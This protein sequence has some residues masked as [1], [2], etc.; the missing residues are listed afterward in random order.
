[1]QRCSRK[2]ALTRRRE[3]YGLASLWAGIHGIVLVMEGNVKAGKTA[4]KVHRSVEPYRRERDVY[5][6]LSEAGVKQILG[7]RV[8][9]LIR[10]DDG[11][12]IVEMTVVTRPFVLDFAGAY[13]D[14]PPE[15]S[16][17]VWAEWQAAKREQFGARWTEVLA[18][19]GALEQLDIHMVDVSPT[20]IAF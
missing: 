10:S 16:E 15:F 17:E 12:Q 7:F 8:P 11:L 9:Q 1:M 20:N 4:V 3:T 18:V 13:I 2:P 6:R 5:L 14:F 19:L